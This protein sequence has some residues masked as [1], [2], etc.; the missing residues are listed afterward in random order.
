[1]L[2]RRRCGVTIEMDDAATLYERGMLNP[3]VSSPGS[4]KSIAYTPAPLW[5]P[6]PVINNTTKG[7]GKRKAEKKLFKNKMPW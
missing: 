1:M 6:H 7:R 2:R 5:S 4:P 3:T